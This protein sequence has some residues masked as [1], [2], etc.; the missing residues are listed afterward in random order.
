MVWLF[1]I[2]ALAPAAAYLQAVFPDWS[3]LYVVPAQG[4]TGSA[5]GSVTGSVTESMNGSMNGSASGSMSRVMPIFAG[6]AMIASALIGWAAAERTGRRLGRLGWPQVTSRLLTALG[7]GMAGLLL[8]LIVRGRLRLV[9]TYEQFHDGQWLMQPLFSTS[10]KLPLALIVINAGVIVALG[11]GV[12][13]LRWRSDLLI[14]PGVPTPGSG[15][16]RGSAAVSH[17]AAEGALTS[18]RSLPT[19]PAPPASALASRSPRPGASGA[20][21]NGLAGEGEEPGYEYE[22]Q[23]A[24]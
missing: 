23:S 10:S 14:A 5:T 19:S 7:L 22:S 11:L 4:L 20:G 16:S 18:E 6:L 2:F 8:A 3:L 1:A 9:G 12:Q 17:A 15:P 13:L 24:R 21:E